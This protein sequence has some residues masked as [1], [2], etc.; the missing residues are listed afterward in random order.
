MNYLKQSD[1]MGDM[2]HQEDEPSACGLCGIPQRSHF[3]RWK[4]G[5]G[6]HP[7]VAPT[8]EQIKKRMF[9]RR[10]RR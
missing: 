1:Q 2:V 3:Q 9:L 5:V 6:W 4:K 7:Y 8:Q 10:K